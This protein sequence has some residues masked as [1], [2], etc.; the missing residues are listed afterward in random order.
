MYYTEGIQNQNNKD[1]YT[2]TT[3]KFQRNYKNGIVNGEIEDKK[4]YDDIES[5]ILQTLESIG[6]S[7]KSVGTYNLVM[8]IESLF[9]IREM[10]QQLGVL[11]DIPY[12]YISGDEYLDLDNPSCKMFL[13]VSFAS[14][15]SGKEFLNTIQEAKAKAN[16]ETLSNNEI[17]YSI[18]ADLARNAEEVFTSQR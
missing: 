17:V 6:F 7:K 4:F 9:Y 13:S 2:I 5:T 3:G 11:G 16:L 14:A 12:E 8:V 18:V 15:Y 10:L 1:F